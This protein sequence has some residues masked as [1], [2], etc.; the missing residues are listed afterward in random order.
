MNKKDF[1]YFMCLICALGMGLLIII[2]KVLQ[3]FGML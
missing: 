2:I 3:I 1:N